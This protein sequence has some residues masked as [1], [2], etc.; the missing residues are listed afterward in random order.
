[1]AESRAVLHGLSRTFR[2]PK[3]TTKYIPEDR[4]LRFVGAAFQPWMEQRSRL[5]SRRAGLGLPMD[6]A[7]DQAGRCRVRLGIALLTSVEVNDIHSCNEYR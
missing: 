6:T 3:A 2:T 5:E 7:A 1:M 4:I